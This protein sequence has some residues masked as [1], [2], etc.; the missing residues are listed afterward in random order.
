MPDFSSTIPD[1]HMKVSSGFVESVLQTKR[2]A[3]YTGLVRVHYPSGE[4]LVFTLIN[5]VQEKLYRSNEQYMDVIPRPSWSSYT[6]R[7]D[8]AIGFLDLPVEALRLMRVVHEAPIIKSE[9]KNFTV[10]DLSNNAEKWVADSYP[11]IIHIQRE[12]VNML[13]LIAGY[14]APIIEQLTFAGDQGLFSINDASFANF[15]PPAEYDVTRYIS[16]NQYDVWQEYE[17][18]FAF[19]PLMRMLIIRFSE[20]A[21][22]V[23]T[24]RLCEQLSIWVKDG[25]WKVDI[26]TNGLANHHYFESLDDEKHAYV[27]ILRSFNGLAS[28]AIGSRMTDTFTHESLLKLNPYHRT[29]LQRH[30]SDLHDF[31][32]AAVRA[33]GTQS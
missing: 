33:G 24:E 20:L 23:L 3:L 22:R 19:N 10:K 9:Q 1:V 4:N 26:T 7:P 27:E 30:I 18:R 5:G 25:G 6:N 8:A 16:D 2:E 31:E 15:L 28:P 12:S 29:L 32:N 13:Y 14:S 11:S 21:G 17:L